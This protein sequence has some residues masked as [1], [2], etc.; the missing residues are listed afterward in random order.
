MSKKIR[1][2][3]LIVLGIWIMLYG[4]M[5][6]ATWLAHGVGMSWADANDH[7]WDYYWRWIV[8]GVFTSGGAILSA[9]GINWDRM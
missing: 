3:I 7:L 2:R 5:L 6:S 4:I 1:D 8:C 9:S